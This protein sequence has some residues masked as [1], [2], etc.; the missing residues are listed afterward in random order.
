[1][2]TPDHTETVIT[3]TPLP[4]PPGVRYHAVTCAD[5]ECCESCPIGDPAVKGGPR[6]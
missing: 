5:G 4:V 3:A 2:T 6:A 1:M